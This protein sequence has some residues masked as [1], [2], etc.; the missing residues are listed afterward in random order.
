MT[1]KVR[2]LSMIAAVLVFSV[3]VWSAVAAQEATVEPTAEATTEAPPAV[4]E[5]TAEAMP[6]SG[7]SMTS[8]GRPFLGVSLQESA[9][10]V[11]VVE[12]VA[13]SGAETAGLQAGD[14]ITSVN[15]TAVTTVA[16]VA[17]AVGALA[18]GDQVTL[19]Y[20]RD[21]A[22]KTTT[23]TLGEQTDAQ[24]SMPGQDRNGQNRPGDQRGQ[25]WPGS[26]EQMFGFQYNSDDQTWTISKLSEDNPLYATG[27]REGD[28]IT[29]V[30]GKTYDPAGLMQHMMSLD[31]DATVTLSVERDG[32]AQEITVTPS[33]LM[34]MGF[35]GMG[36]FRG[37]DNG[38]FH[39]DF[40][41]MMPMMQ[42]AYG[43]GRLGVAFQPLD[44]EL[45]AEQNLS[46]SEGALITEVQ[47]DTPAATAGLQVNDVVTAVNGEPVDEE[48][49]L[50]DRLIA[51][52]PGDTVT[53]TVLRDGASEEIEVTLDEPQMSGMGGLFGSLPFNFHDFH[54]G[55]PF[56]MQPGQDGMNAA[57]E[58]TATPNA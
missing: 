53:L 54:G 19:D 18:I 27:L 9:D 32:A 17:D 1:K 55:L 44:A 36:L 56:D 57:P 6:E 40:G 48:H 43:N 14:I 58:A 22:A 7:T 29:A 49:T 47:A 46:V 13:G 28:V 21:G 3:L 42:S 41:Q 5:A 12:V 33:D 37:G 51:Y 39:G 31:A 30:D 24:P 8:E 34:G 52:E 35:G 20:T 11:T 26:I 16:E 4:V 2:S 10:G 23:A 25:N 15:G 50:R 38:G 45:A